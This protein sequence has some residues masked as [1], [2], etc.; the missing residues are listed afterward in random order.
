MPIE[1]E[2]V[3]KIN[4]ESS[5]E[6][7]WLDPNDL[8]ARI[9]IAQFSFNSTDDLKAGESLAD[10]TS[11]DLVKLPSGA[12][13]L[14]IEGNFEDFGAS[15]QLDIGLRGANSSGYD[16]AGTADDPD[17]LDQ[18]IDVSSAGTLNAAKNKTAFGYI[19]SKEVY[20]TAE[21]NGAVPA[22]DKDLDGVVYYTD[23]T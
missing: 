22:A 14:G 15:V 12:R 19:T 23:N 16:K 4:K 11:I 2:Q 13:L 3:T 21:L 8:G 7:H 1:S 10:P 6:A 17:F 20:V 5:G 9:R 18:N